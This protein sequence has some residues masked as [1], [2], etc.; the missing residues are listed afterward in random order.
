[1]GFFRLYFCSFARVMLYST[2]E[3]TYGETRSPKLIPIDYLFPV[4]TI[5]E[6]RSKR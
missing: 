5:D 1:M 4:L 6:T 2:S 3:S